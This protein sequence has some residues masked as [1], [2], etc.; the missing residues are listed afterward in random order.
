MRILLLCPGMHPRDGGPPRTVSGSAMALKRAG[1]AVEIATIGRPEDEVETRA[2]WSALSD[3]GVPIHIFPRDFPYVIGRSD[4]LKRF[5]R[6][7]AS[8]FDLLHVHCVWETALA[9]GAAIFRR[10]GK[11]TMVSAHGMLDRWQMQRSALKKALAMRFLG[12]G[13]MLDGADGVLY[14][15][16]EE[17]GEAE[18]LALASRVVIMPN[19]VEPWLAGSEGAGD[20]ILIR[21]PAVRGWKRTILFFSRMHPKKGVDLLVEAFERLHPYFPDAGLLIAAI[22]QDKN[23]GDAI[24]EKI[25]EYKTAN[26]VLVNEPDGL[27]AEDV[28]AIADIFCLPSHQEGFSQA[29]LEAAAASLPELITDK[30]HIPEIEEFGAGFVVPDTVDGIEG[31]LRAL[32]AMDDKAL[33][34]MGQNGKRLVDG[35]YTWDRIA[36]RLIDAYQNAISKR[37]LQQV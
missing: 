29:I 20:Q 4:A 1:I 31:G 36:Q 23:Y 33:S 30:C 28:F 11:P 26:I 24:R 9:D 14:G 18:P 10:R 2:R 21:F 6:K 15:T 19:G 5:L 27:K 13:A 3:A 7:E 17:A 35:S 12:T 22:A 25:A 16:Q 34:V 37:G 32:L 8:R